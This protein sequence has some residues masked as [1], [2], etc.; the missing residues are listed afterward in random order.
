VIR[1]KS[2]EDDMQL[3]LYSNL[4]NIDIN[5]RYQK[6][7]SVPGTWKLVPLSEDEGHVGH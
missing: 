7:I 3:W 5:R 2:K 1:E 4:S 6:V